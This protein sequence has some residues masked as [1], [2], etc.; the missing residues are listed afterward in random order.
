[1]RQLMQV[2]P[3]VISLVFLRIDRCYYSLRCAVV[4]LDEG[5][6]ACRSDGKAP[7]YSPETTE[8]VAAY[9]EGNQTYILCNPP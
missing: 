3:V 6:D 2:T 9:L 5:F 1:M 7:V 8:I 4:A